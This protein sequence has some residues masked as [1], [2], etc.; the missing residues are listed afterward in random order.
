MLMI[1]S[2]VESFVMIV[3]TYVPSRITVTRSVITLISSIRCEMYTIAIF[4]FLRS[5]MIS[6]IA[7]ISVSV[8]AA[9]GSSKIITFASKE[10]AFAIS[11]I[12]CLPTVK[13]DIVSAGS[14]STFNLSKSFFASSFIFLSSIFTPFINSRP[15][16]KFCATV[17]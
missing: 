12:C 15:M 10:T 9:E 16:N 8:R 7:S 5:R 6:N 4:L 17:R 13:L 11:H 14:M 3:P 1:S 2:F